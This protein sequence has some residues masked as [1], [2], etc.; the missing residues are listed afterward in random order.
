[1]SLLY[2][3]WLLPL[4]AVVSVVYSAARSDDWNVIARE[5]L[6][7]FGAFVLGIVILAAVLVVFSKVIQPL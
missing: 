2:F 3:L 6:R 5:S 1:M 7:R 4:C